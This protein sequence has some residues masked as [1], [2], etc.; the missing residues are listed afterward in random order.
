MWLLTELL[1]L[2]IFLSTN[3]SLLRSYPSTQI[4]FTSIAGHLTKS[5]VGAKYIPLHN[6]RLNFFDFLCCN[7]SLLRSYPSTQI[8]F[9]SI[10]GHL[11]KSSV[12]AK[13]IPLYN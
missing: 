9:T 12:A 2:I 1:N 11:T 13:Y 8:K 10:A 3:I 6:E 5:S 4:K 7:I